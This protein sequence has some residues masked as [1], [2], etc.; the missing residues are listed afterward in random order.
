MSMEYC[1]KHGQERDT[2]FQI[3]CLDCMEDAYQDGYDAFMD[4]RPST[5][6]PHD[7][8]SEAYVWWLDGY[9]TAVFELRQAG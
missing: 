7:P 8:K 5:T 6:N 2:D 9:R 1:H 3:E 4:N